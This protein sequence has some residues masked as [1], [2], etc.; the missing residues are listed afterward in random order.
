MVKKT[1]KHFNMNEFKCPCG[2]E[3]LIYFELIKKLDEAR[4]IAN[5]P[6]RITSGYRCKHHNSIVGGSK[7]S[8]HLKG[9]AVD[10]ACDNSENRYKIISALSQVG[11]N[12]IGVARNFIHCD[13]DKDKVNN[14]LWTY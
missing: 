13:I 6:F 3:N 7:T 4:E 14:V 10:I 2:G 1:I 9:L 11:F 12:R 8:S 5:I